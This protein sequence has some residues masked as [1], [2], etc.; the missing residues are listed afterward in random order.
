MS[1]ILVKTS[2]RNNGCR[3]WACSVCDYVGSLRAMKGRPCPPVVFANPVPDD[4]DTSDDDDDTSDDD[5]G[6]PQ[7]R[8]RSDT[9]PDL[10]PHCH[11]PR[12]SA[13]CQALHP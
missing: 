8:E 12:N 7:P 10:C 11:F 6:D 13:S 2:Q 5:D 1:H 9:A 3:V 4:D